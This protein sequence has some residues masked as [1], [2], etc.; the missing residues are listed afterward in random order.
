MGNEVTVEIGNAGRRAIVILECKRE[1]K[2]TLVITSQFGQRHSI[3]VTVSKA[4]REELIAALIE[5]RETV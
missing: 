2:A 4:Q 3:E 1:G 5:M